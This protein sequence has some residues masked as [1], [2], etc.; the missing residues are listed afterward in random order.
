[1]NITEVQP[2]TPNAQGIFAN[3]FNLGGTSSA[4]FVLEGGYYCLSAVS[5]WGTYATSTL[6]MVN[7]P[8]AGDTVTVGGHAYR[9]ELVGNLAQAYD[10]TLPAAGT[11]A[12]KIQGALANLAAVIA[13]IASTNAQGYTSTAN[14][15]VTATST[16]TTLTATAKAVG[17][18]ANSY[19]VSTT[20]SGN[21]WSPATDMAG[22]AAGTIAL[23]ILGPDGSTLINTA[24]TLSANGEVLGYLPAGTYQITQTTNSGTS[25]SVQSVPI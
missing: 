9:F 2:Q 19:G 24:L 25:A 15:E 14:S 23:Q 1:M 7:L 12:A 21:T 17:T 4:K 22:G 20:T 16:A 8:A 3:A 5:N 10:V 13:G 6:T 11:T 18:A